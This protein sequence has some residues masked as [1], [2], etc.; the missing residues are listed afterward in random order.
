MASR[1]ECVII[2]DF[3][4]V[5]ASWRSSVYDARNE[6]L[7]PPAREFSFNPELRGND[8]MLVASVARAEG[9]SYDAALRLVR[10]DVDSMRSQLVSYGDVPLGKLGVLHFNSSDSTITFT[11]FPADRLSVATAWLCP[12]PAREAIVEARRRNG[13]A[14]VA[15]RVSPFR[16]A[17]RVAASFAVLLGIG[18]VASTP[19]S[20]PED[21]TYA[22]LAPEVSATETGIPSAGISA[23]ASAPI[24]MMRS[25][26]DGLWIDVPEEVKVPAFNLD[27]KY[28][29]VVSSH[30]S[31]AEA[32]NFVARHSGMPLGI[33]EKDGRY[34]VYAATGS[35][36]AE[37][38]QA[39]A[40]LP[41]AFPSAWVCRR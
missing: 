21:V 5:L 38:E 20:V 10:D 36:I 41:E 4:A 1:R 8:G 17:V 16:K 3:G 40:L 24:I 29:L 34:R 19:M 33:L 7:L 11:P 15:I 27:G 12:I 14:P 26:G 28:C 39:K 13:D 32:E 25:S 37:A 2:P 18:I 6:V 31:M 23:P 35:T 30:A 9:I 22:S